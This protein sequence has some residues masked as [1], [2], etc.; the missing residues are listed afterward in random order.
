MVHQ[1]RINQTNTDK[2]LPVVYKHY[3]NGL[4]VT[5]YLF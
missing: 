3:Q 2:K 1:S 5:G 4:I